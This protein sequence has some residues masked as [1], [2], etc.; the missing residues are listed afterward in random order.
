VLLA[1]LAARVL[2]ERGPSRHAKAAPEGE[3]AR[4]VVP[5]RAP[6]HPPAAVLPAPKPLTL[7][8]VP[9]PAQWSR[10]AFGSQLPK[11]DFT[12]DLDH[13]APLGD[14]PANTAIWLRD[15]ARSDGSRAAEVDHSDLVPVSFLGRE[16]RVY[17]P[18]HPLLLEA[19]PWVDQA[20]CLFYPD[21]WA[22]EGAGMPVANLAFA[23]NLARSWTARGATQKDPLRAREDYRRAIRL[24]RLLMQEDFVEVQ[25][26]VGWA[27]VSF[28]LRGL[29]DLARREGDGPML[30]ATTLALGDYE[31]MR[32]I[33]A[34]WATELR[35]DTAMR[36]SWWGGWSLSDD[37]AILDRALAHARDNPLHC[38]RAEAVHTLVALQHVG[39]DAQREKAA[40]TVAELARG[41]DARIAALA[42]WLDGHFGA[43]DAHHRR[44]D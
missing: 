5:S 9:A 26:L 7:A 6:A 23:V 31:A 2:I 40:A 21:I 20:S 12:L 33:A 44:Q 39:T 10:S 29:N 35:L 24:G 37:G 15:F 43:R 30:A 16:Q 17:P 11:L 41:E 38:L 19:E 4:A 42:R 32:G 1:L 25:Q 3:A 36:Q 27:C 22:A 28:G 8:D 13:F 18:D 34:Q 14:G